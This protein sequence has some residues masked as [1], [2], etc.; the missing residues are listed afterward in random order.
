MSKVKLGNSNRQ[1]MNPVGV[2][3]GVA[4]DKG[5]IQYPNET[6]KKYDL[7]TLGF[8]GVLVTDGTYKIAPA[9]YR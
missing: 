9:K 7:D 4:E 3:F 8:I 5:I 2:H 6:M 1:V